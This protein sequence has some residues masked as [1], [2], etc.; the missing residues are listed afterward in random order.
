MKVYLQRKKRIEFEKQQRIQEFWRALN[1]TFDET[2][3]NDEEDP[4]Y[5]E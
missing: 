3:E 2:A 5:I 4:M 1:E